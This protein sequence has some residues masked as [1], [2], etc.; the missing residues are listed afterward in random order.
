MTL[1]ALPITSAGR[2][3]PRGP[4]GIARLVFELL[5]YLLVLANCINDPLPIAFSRIYPRTRML[6]M[7]SADSGF[8]EPIKLA[9]ETLNVRADL[10]DDPRPRYHAAHLISLCRAS[11]P[12]KEIGTESTDGD[13]PQAGHNFKLRRYLRATV[14]A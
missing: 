2:F 12:S 6:P 14:R 5:G 11:T 8:V 10:V 4:L 13:P 1:T 9:P 3:S 7:A